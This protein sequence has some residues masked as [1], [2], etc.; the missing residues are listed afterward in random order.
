M[1][2]AFGKFIEKNCLA[3]LWFLS[4]VIFLILMI[5]Y[6]IGLFIVIISMSFFA[7]LPIVREKISLHFSN[8]LGIL[9]VIGHF[10]EIMTW[11]K[12]LIIAMYQL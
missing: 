3:I 5:V 6:F 7:F 2:I 10:Y 1:N 11:A 4:S 12:Y 8:I 9:W